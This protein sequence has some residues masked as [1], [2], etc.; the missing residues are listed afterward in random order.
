MSGTMGETTN[1]TSPSVEQA[2]EEFVTPWP[3]DD[4][5]L[6]RAQ[7]RTLQQWLI[8]QGHT[9]IVADGIVGSSTR[10]AIEAERAKKGM[11]PARRVG[12]KSMEEL[13]GSAR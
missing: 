12:I 10:N 6:S 11:P 1:R 9:K 4:P 7:V 13:I 5:G 3:T 2:M 8:A